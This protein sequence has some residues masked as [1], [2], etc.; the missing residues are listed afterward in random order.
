VTAARL[1]LI[2]LRDLARSI[3]GDYDCIHECEE[4]GGTLGY[5]RGKPCAD[6]GCYKCMAVRALRYRNRKPRRSHG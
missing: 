6:C 1:R 3:A 4:N 5:V 2:L